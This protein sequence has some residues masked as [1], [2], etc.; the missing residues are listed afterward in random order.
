V[1]GTPIFMG[2]Y[3]VCF[4]VHPCLL[5]ADGLR[6]T[7]FMTRLRALCRRVVS[8]FFL[9]ADFPLTEMVTSP[10]TAMRAL[11]KSR[12]SAHPL[13]AKRR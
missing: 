4:S 12:C 10:I 9:R 3:C 13:L 1:N 11:T 5:I 6:Y 2:E 8:T 7:F